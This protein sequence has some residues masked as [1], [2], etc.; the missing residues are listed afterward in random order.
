MISFPVG[1]QRIRC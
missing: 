1:G